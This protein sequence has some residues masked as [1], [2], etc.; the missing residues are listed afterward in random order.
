MKT[1][2]PICFLIIISMSSC[3]TTQVAKTPDYNYQFALVEVNSVA[4]DTTTMNYIDDKIEAQ[5][6][7]G[8]SSIS[9]AIKN[10]TNDVMKIVWD[11]ASLVQYGVAKKVMH[12]GVKYTEAHNSQPPTSMPP[13]SSISDL[14][15]PADNVKYVE[16]YYSTYYSRSPRWDELPLLDRAGGDVNQIFS[17]YL[18]IQYLDKTLNYNFTFRAY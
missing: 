18:P 10:L 17:L 11:E 2:Y 12:A 8:V 3:F 6:S 14:V 5:F 1:I 4:L 7:V 9:F 15:L 13:K 16:G